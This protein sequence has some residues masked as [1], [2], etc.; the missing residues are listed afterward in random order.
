MGISCCHVLV[1][2][3]GSID[4]CALGVVLSL[5]HGYAVGHVRYASSCGWSWNAFVSLVQS[6]HDYH[7]YESK[8]LIMSCN[9]IFFVP[10]MRFSFPK[11]LLNPYIY[12]PSQPKCKYFF[13]HRKNNR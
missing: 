7:Y 9:Y 13:L 3:D 8:C 10:I 12:L 4:G 1:M 2:I 11:V 5:L 6:G